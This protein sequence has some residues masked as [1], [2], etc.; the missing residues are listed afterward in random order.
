VIDAEIADTDEVSA[1]GEAAWRVQQQL[2]AL[3]L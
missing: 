3:G 1:R 2:I